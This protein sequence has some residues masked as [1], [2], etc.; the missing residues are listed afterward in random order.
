MA[1]YVEVVSALTRQQRGG[2]LT[3]ADMTT[4]LA[5]FQY[6]YLNQYQIVEVIPVVI[7]HAMSLAQHHALR[8]YDAVQLAAA[9]EVAIR[10][11][12]LI[13]PTLTLISADSA[14]NV[15]ATT[16]GLLVDDPNL[17]I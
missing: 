15:A 4:A 3:Y 1:N 8:G 17:H 6:D 9:V 16:E 2:F 11:R 13:S 12:I 14:L 5:Q 10:L 7:Q